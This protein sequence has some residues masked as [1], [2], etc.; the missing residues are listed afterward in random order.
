MRFLRPLALAV[1]GASL[2]RAAP[3]LELTPTAA[4]PKIDGHLDDLAWKS[5]A[6]TDAFRQ[7]S[8][9]ENVAPTERTE[10]WVT[11]DAD[12]I[13]VAVR[14]DDSG[15][16]EGIRAYSMQRDQDNGSDDV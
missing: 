10:F 11:Y 5:A 7:V 16:T 3:A 4:P 2:L 8:P 1:L 13:Y 14:C 6:H 9:Q 15:G 12:A